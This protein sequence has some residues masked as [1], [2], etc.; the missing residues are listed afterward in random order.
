MNE[1]PTWKDEFGPEYEVP[2][3]ILQLEGI[4]D[5]SWHNN[6]CP[7]FGVLSPDGTHELCIW[8]DHPDPD[9]RE[10]CGSRFL[11]QRYEECSP[12]EDLYVGD[13]DLAAIRAFMEALPDFYRLV[14]G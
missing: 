4:S 7:S 3:S 12:I 5:M 1:S 10:V 14:K 13:D 9:E 6:V 2:Q 11:V 8:T